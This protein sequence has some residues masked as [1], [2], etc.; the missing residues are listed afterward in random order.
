MQ[1]PSFLHRGSCSEVSVVLGRPAHRGALCENWHVDAFMP[2]SRC[3]QCAP[4]GCHNAFFS[5]S[6]ARPCPRSDGI[7]LLPSVPGI[8]VACDSYS[9][10]PGS[11]F[12]LNSLQASLRCADATKTAFFIPSECADCPAVEV[13]DASKI[14]LV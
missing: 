2:P 12:A 3:S 7:P 13:V 5:L 8:I 9:S 14:A 4:E 6:G 11:T 1:R 10:H